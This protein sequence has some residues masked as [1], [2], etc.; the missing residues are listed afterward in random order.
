M[1]DDPCMA[2]IQPPETDQ[3]GQ[4]LRRHPRRGLGG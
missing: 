1:H 2:A 3:A 4:V